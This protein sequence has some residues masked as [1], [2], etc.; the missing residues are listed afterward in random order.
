MSMIKDIQ[1]IAY[2]E[3]KAPWFMCNFNQNGEKTYGHW[4]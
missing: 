4:H 2:L 3:N 1:F